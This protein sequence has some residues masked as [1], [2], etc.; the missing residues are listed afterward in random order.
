MSLYLICFEEKKKRNK[1]EPRPHRPS[2][3][4]G[5]SFSSQKG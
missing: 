2:K 4:G 5:L 3:L 1:G